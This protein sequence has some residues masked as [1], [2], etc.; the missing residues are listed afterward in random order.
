M[1][2]AH[3]LD[4]ST[5]RR[6]D[7]GRFNKSSHHDVAAAA[8][9]KYKNMFRRFC[10]GHWVLVTKNENSGKQEEFKTCNV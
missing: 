3:L 4:K 5:G 1:Y 9:E 8:R 6:L 10:S 7:L 2:T